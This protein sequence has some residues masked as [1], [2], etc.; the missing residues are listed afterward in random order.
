MVAFFSYIDAN[1]LILTVYSPEQAEA[2]EH[3]LKVA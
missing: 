1:Q 2:T 3:V